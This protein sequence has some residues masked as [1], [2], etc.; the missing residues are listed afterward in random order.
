LAQLNPS[1]YSH[2]EGRITQIIVPSTTNLIYRT[3][4]TVNIKGLHDSS[5]INN[6]GQL[7]SL[8]GFFA[9]AATYLRRKLQFNEAKYIVN[10]EGTDKYINK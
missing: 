4:L 10:E 8:T 7:Q 6:T 5:L 1:C 9:D 2:G 3:K